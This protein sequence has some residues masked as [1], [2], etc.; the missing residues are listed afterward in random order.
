MVVLHNGSLAE[1]CGKMLF[2]CSSDALLPKEGAQDVAKWHN[3]VELELAGNNVK[4]QEG[5]CRG[6]VLFIRV[7]FLTCAA[8]SPR[9]FYLQFEACL[10]FGWDSRKISRWV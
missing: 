3:D 6:G 10:I 8:R 2:S 5:G 7:G 4:K 1:A 9:R